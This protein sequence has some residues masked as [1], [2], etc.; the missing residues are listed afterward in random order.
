MTTLYKPSDQAWSWFFVITCMCM[1]LIFE[2]FGVDTNL[3]SGV[4]G[5]GLQAYTSTSKKE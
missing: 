1:V 3:A 5:A 2:H 4:I